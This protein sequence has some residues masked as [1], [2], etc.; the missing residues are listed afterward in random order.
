MEND[1]AFVGRILSR[2][3]ILR[4][5]GVS[6]ISGITVLAGC[7]GGGAGGVGASGS[8]GAALLQITWPTASASRLIPAA[9]NSIKVTFSLNGTVIATQT[10]A[11]PSSGNTSTLTF[12]GL[13]TGTLSAKSEAFP[14]T[15]GTG[16]A[17]ATATVAAVITAGQTTPVTITMASSIDNLTIT[18]TLTS[19][20]VGAS[21]TLTLTAYDASSAVVLTSGSTI[22][23]TSLTPAI[24]S[25]TSAGVMTGIAAGSAQI[26]ATDS[27][28][29][30]SATISL[31]VSSGG[32]INL[33]ASPA[34]TEGPFFVDEKLNRSNILGST[35]RTTVVNGI[36]L[37]LNLGVY[38]VS[39]GL[40]TPLAG[41]Q[42]DVWHADAA[43]T[44]SDENNTGIQSENT[45][46]QN[47]L[48]GYQVSDANGAV[49]FTTIYPGWYQ[50]RTIHMHFKVRIFN[51]SGSTAYEF[52]SQFFIN[53][54]LNDI[55]MAKSP[56]NTR[57]TRTVRNAND[58]IYSGTGNDSIT[59]GTQLS[60]TMTDNGSGGYIGA[61]NIGLAM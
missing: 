16:V 30:K 28:S 24:A 14:T 59:D 38:K 52:T 54:T 2:R 19:V 18:S 49:S 23:W 26:Q 53:D 56:Y 33:V 34:L 37:T 40:G 51:T 13:T 22:T 36:P 32:T 42:V 4:L 3:E 10:A 58:S 31:S 61:F 5:A 21:N 11:R 48:R 12:T 57:G 47:W 45:L 41:A 60:L 29:G 17:Q 9:A 43:G 7:G 6:G 44:Y 50:G 55:V 1:D 8:T 27:E 15:D 35:T 20:Q 25:V 39:N 46:G